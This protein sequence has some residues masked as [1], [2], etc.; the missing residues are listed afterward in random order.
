[1]PS[2]PASP[3]RC[4]RL[5]KSTNS[6]GVRRGRVIVEREDPSALL[7]DEPA[8]R[9]VRRLQHGNRRREVQAREGARRLDAGA[10]GGRI[11][12]I[13]VPA[14]AIAA[15]AGEQRGR[16]PGGP[17]DAAL[18]RVLPSVVS[19]I[20]DPSDGAKFLRRRFQGR[21]VLSKAEADEPRRRR[22]VA[23]RRQRNGRHAVPA[24]QHFAERR[25]G[26]VRHRRIVGQL[27]I[28]PVHGP[29]RRSASPRAVP[30]SGR[31]AP[32]RRR[33]ARPRTPAA[34]RMKSAIAC[35]TGVE[36]AKVR[37]WCTLRNS[38]VSGGA[39]TQ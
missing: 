2:R 36:T 27:E 20:G 18:H 32:G 15:A 21:V 7:D 23:E 28:C 9:V 13:R 29:Q 34:S 1:M 26:Q 33:P 38:A 10:A 19:V 25:V 17:E 30:R 22:L 35:C 3:S 14:A 16:E 12:R 8:R 37:N 39:A 6:I 5:R 24:R 4:T 31:A 11:G